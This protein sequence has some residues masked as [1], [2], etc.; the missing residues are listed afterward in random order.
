MQQFLTIM[1]T[2]I[3]EGEDS[4]FEANN[5]CVGQMCF[6]GKRQYCSCI[7]EVMHTNSPQL[8]ILSNQILSKSRSKIGRQIKTRSQHTSAMHTCN[9]G[10]ILQLQNYTVH[11]IQSKSYYKQIKFIHARTNNKPPYMHY[12]C[13][14]LAQEASSISQSIYTCYIAPAP[15]ITANHRR[16]TAESW[17]SVH[18][19]SKQCQKV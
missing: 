17:S 16:M 1:K 13:N 4:L 14:Q 8:C 10:K 18:V 19:Y 9:W 11:I 15:Y 3:F 2:R 6:P 12:D 7:T 5:R